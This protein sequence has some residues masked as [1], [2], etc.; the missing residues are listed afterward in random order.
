MNIK[1]VESKLVCETV[2]EHFKVI[3]NGKEVWINKWHRSDN[4]LDQYDGDTEI[5][6]GLELLTEEEQEAVIDYVNEESEVVHD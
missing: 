3:V 1:I 2:E 6:K 4:D 5:Y